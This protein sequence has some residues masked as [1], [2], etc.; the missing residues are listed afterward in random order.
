DAG[1]DTGDVA[2]AM[3]VEPPAGRAHADNRQDTNPYRPVLISDD[4]FDYAYLGY[5]PAEVASRAFRASIVGVLLFPPLLN[6]YSIY[7]LLKIRRVDLEHRPPAQRHRV[8]A[9][10]IN[11]LSIPIWIYLWLIV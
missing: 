3:E 1:A 10:R 7:L 8:I 9:W 5:D 2:G 4:Q 6:F 11:L